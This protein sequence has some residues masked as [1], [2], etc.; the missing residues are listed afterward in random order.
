MI[1]SLAVAIFRA[2]FPPTVDKALAS[3]DRA[4]KALTRAAEHAT[5]KAE[6][7]K[8]FRADALNMAQRH[9]ETILAANDDARRAVRIRARLADLVA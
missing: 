7:H 4:S 5:D 3:L 1:K 2:F 6:A 9:E 8:V